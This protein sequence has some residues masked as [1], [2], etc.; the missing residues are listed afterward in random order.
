M[1]DTNLQLKQLDDAMVEAAQ[2]AAE[3][4]G[5]ITPELKAK[6]DACLID[7]KAEYPKNEFLFSVDDGTLVLLGYLHKEVE[8][9][10]LAC[11]NIVEVGAEV[12]DAI[13][14][15]ER[16]LID[17]KKIADAFLHLLWCQRTEVDQMNMLC[18]SIGIN[19]SHLCRLEAK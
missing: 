17:L 5:S 16:R 7:M 18:Q 10:V 14:D 19:A 1:E 15:D 13:D 6:L 9:Q 3:G 12:N 2:M 4:T 8:H 11:L